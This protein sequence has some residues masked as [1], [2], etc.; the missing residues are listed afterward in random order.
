MDNVWLAKLKHQAAIVQISSEKVFRM[1]KMHNFNEQRA[2]TALRL[3]RDG[4]AAFHIFSNQ[5]RQADLK[6]SYY[7]AAAEVD[8]A[9]GKLVRLLLAKLLQL[10]AVEVGEESTR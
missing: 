3:V 7:E 4:Q 1:M 9:W 5:I 2:Q 10:Q 8:D 6:P